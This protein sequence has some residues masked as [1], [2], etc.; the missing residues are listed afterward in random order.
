[1]RI[2]E[3][4][5]KIKK[6]RIIIYILIIAICIVSI[7]IGFYIQFYGRIDIGKVIGT[8]QS[9]YGNKTEDEIFE[10]ES[11]FTNIF[12]NTVKNVSEQNND[13]RKDK[14]REIVYS[15]YNKKEELSGK[16]NLNLNIPQINIENDI[17]KKY[18]K[19][20]KDVFYGKVENIFRD[21]EK[22]KNVVYTVS[23]VAE[24]HQ[25]ILSLMIISNL[26]EGANPQRV[27]VQTYNYDLRNNKEIT[28]E[29]VLETERLDKDLVQE[30]ID[31]EI[32]N[33]KKKADDLNSLGYKTFNRDTGSDIYNIENSKYYYLT[34]NEI[35]II[36]PYGNETFTSEIDM[37]I[38]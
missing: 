36:Y 5:V 22:N 16:Y 27:I 3:E 29:K 30:K 2:Y 10:L 8:S 34:N 32:E 15:A 31:R 35:Y 13:K 37:V 25:D 14:N 17:I 20:I 19:E 38:L 12:D 7:L 23:Y 21:K 28:L 33:K 6:K 26:K 18:N 9:V 24:I 11:N 1:M 4:D